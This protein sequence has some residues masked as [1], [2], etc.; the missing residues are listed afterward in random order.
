MVFFLNADEWQKVNLATYPRSGNHWMRFLIEEATNIATSSTYR[1]SDPLHLSTKFPWGGYCPENGYEGNRR[2]PQP[3]EIVVIKTHFPFLKRFQPSRETKSIRIVRHPVDSIYSLYLYLNKQN[4]DIFLN[5]R[6][7]EFTKEIPKD[8]LDKFIKTWREFQE[9]WN[10]PKLNV[11]TVR[12]ED[13]MTNPVFYF[14]EIM[15][16]IG[17]NAT[18]EDIQRAC[19]KYPPQGKPLKHLSSFSKEQLL[20]INSELQEFMEQFGYSIPE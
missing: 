14:G 17:Y 2:Y 1:D 8:H 16:A 19:D 9:Y 18:P 10:D 5:Q 20:Q 13:L 4:Y 7:L 12:Y 6:K 3:G 15:K 11:F